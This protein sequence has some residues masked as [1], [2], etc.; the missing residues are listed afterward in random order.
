[1]G[2]EWKQL[3]ELGWRGGLGG[4]PLPLVVLCAGIMHSILL[5]L[6]ELQ[7][8]QLGFWPF[9]ILLIICPN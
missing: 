2:R 7:K 6:P 8:W 4:L 5:L 9:Y 1:M 3:Q